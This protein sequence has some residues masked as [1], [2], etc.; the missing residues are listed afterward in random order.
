MRKE[1]KLQNLSDWLANDS[2]DPGYQTSLDSSMVPNNY[3]S[4]IQGIILDQWGN[5]QNNATCGACELETCSI[6]LM[7]RTYKSMSDDNRE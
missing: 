4:T 1:I 7:V 5:S 3:A 2:D 6:S